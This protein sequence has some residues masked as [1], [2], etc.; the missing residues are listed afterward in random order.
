MTAWVSVPTPQVVC[1]P[2]LPQLQGTENIANWRCG[3]IRLFVRQEL[4][5]ATNLAID[6][7]FSSGMASQPGRLHQTGNR[8]PG[9]GP[10]DLM[11]AKAI[12]RVAPPLSATRKT[13]AD[14]EEAPRL[15]PRK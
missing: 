9:H 7:F 4:R 2:A 1:E 11:D 5:R 15:A 8:R 13:D 6:D 12:R 14:V 10:R 3:R